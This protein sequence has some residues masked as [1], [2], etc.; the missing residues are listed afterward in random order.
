M[1]SYYNAP[2]LPEEVEGLKKY[3]LQVALLGKPYGT[4]SGG[5]AQAAKLPTLDRVSSLSVNTLKNVTSYSAI[6]GY[7]G[8]AMISIEVIDEIDTAFGPLFV[9]HDPG[10]VGA[11]VGIPKSNFIEKLPARELKRTVLAAAN[12]QTSQ[13]EKATTW[14]LLSNGVAVLLNLSRQYDFIPRD[15]WSDEEW[16]LLRDAWVNRDLVGQYGKRYYTSEEEV[17]LLE[18]RREGLL[19]DPETA[20]VDWSYGNVGTPEDRALGGYT[21]LAVQV[22]IFGF[23]SMIFR[24]KSMRSCGSGAN[25]S[26]PS[27]AAWSF[28]KISRKTG[29]ADGRPR[30]GTVAWIV[31]GQ[32]GRVPFARCESVP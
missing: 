4:I 9:I 10:T 18:R 24:A 16:E 31:A 14:E 17:F 11:H 21:L 6:R 7:T 30:F 22:E 25:G 5:Q 23:R 32:S 19:I 13:L 29:L 1:T 3:L 27:P 8:E 20:E 12:Q 26:S 28:Q 2:D 15:Q